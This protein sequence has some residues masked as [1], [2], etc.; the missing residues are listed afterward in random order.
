MREAVHI[1][2]TENE[3][4]AE[5]EWIFAEFVLIVTCG[6]GPLAAGGIIFAKKMEQVR[7]AEFRGKIG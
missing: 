6:A 3:A 2:R 1:S 4:S 5:L 7:R